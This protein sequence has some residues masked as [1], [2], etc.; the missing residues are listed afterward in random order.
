MLGSPGPAGEVKS[1]ARPSSC[2][3]CGTPGRVGEGKEVGTEEERESSEAYT[4][5][6]Q[7][8]QAFVDNSMCSSCTATVHSHNF[9]FSILPIWVLKKVKEVD[10][11][12]GFIEVPHTQGAQVQIT[13]CY[14]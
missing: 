6:Q 11:Y 3:G 14:L 12:S 9:I 7:T 5:C 10:L 2:I 4:E 8:F 13:Q 1:V